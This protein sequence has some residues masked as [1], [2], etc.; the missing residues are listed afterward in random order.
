MCCYI[1]HYMYVLLYPSLYVCAAISITI[2]MC[3]YIH[4]YMYVLL[5]PSLYVCAAI[6][7]TICMCCY[8]HHYMYVL[9]YPSLYVCA[10]IYIT[11]CMCCYIHHY[12]YVLLY[13]SLYV[14]AAIYIT[15]HTP[16]SFK[17]W[18]FIAISILFYYTTELVRIA[19]PVQRLPTG[20]TV[21]GSNPG[22]GGGDFSAPV[23]TGPEA[24]P[25]SCTMGTGSFPG[26]NVLPGRDADPSPLLI[27]FL[28]QR[29]N[30][31]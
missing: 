3:C 6:S 19:Q 21:R 30:P 17:L 5:Y 25:A 20:W 28:S 15:P 4:H 1:H 9:L 23:Q 12:M 7:I 24:H 16:D 27:F 31:L 26:G 10:A 11:I 18:Q 13:T 8:I 14:C 2:C 22:G 29:Y